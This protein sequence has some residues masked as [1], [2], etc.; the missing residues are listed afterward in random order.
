MQTLLYIHGFLSS[1][2]SI[3]AQ[4]TQQWLSEHYPDTQYLCPYLSSYPSEARK[5]LEQLLLPLLEKGI[6][7][8]L[9]GSSLGGYWSTYLAEQ[10]DLRAVLVNPAVKPSLFLPGYLGKELKN[11][12][13]DDVY[14]LTEKDQQDLRAVDTTDIQRKTSY[15]LLA[16]TGDETLDYRLAVEKYTGCRQTI[17]EG[18]DHGFQN[19]DR[20]LPAIYEF[21]FSR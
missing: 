7:V 6:E 9:I 19:Y 12:H 15:W 3:K 2:K 20:H 14:V 17:E 16:Q 8:G 13:T 10:Y 1:P 5:A 11:Y 18:G 21:L 4:Q